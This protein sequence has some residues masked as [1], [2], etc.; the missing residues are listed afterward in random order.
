MENFNLNQARF[1][2]NQS[3]A[4]GLVKGSQDVSEAQIVN[5]TNINILQNNAQIMPQIDYSMLNLE[6][7][8]MEQE[9]ILKY[10]QNLLN[11]PNSIDKFINEVKNQDSK[12]VK[13]LVENL[14]GTKELGEFLNVNSKEAILKVL[15][16]ISNSLKAGIKDTGDLKQILSILNSI[17]NVSKD[18]NSSSLKELLLLY[19][20]LNN[21]EFDKRLDLSSLDEDEE[22]AIKNKTLSILFETVNF[23]NMLVTLQQDIAGIYI[24]LYC[25]DTFPF[26]KF[27]KV[28]K[29]LSKEASI[30]ILIEAKTIKPKEN[31]KSQKNSFNIISEDYVS[32]DVLI[33]AHIIIK[34]I[35]TIDLKINEA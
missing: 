16:T 34:T 19:I 14:L 7:P 21:L 24:E 10:L 27:N 3:Q 4:A 6:I 30:N 29:T 9:M 8:K 18:L 11:L 26:E 5:N 12:Y 28:L 22:D 25:I 31:K 33:L 23:S 17:Q 20:P 1:N 15:D 32:T 35:L 13:L 2:L